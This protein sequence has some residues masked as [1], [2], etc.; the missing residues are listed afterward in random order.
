VHIPVGIGNEMRVL[1]SALQCMRRYKFPLRA[2]YRVLVDPLGAATVAH[3]VVRD[4]GAV[5]SV[6]VWQLRWPLFL[7]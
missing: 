3:A 4:H 1:K 5:G 7:S 2:A 6:A